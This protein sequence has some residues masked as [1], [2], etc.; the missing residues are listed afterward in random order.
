MQ[1]FYEF[2]LNLINSR[3]NLLREAFRKYS[4]AKQTP[5][6][7]VRDFATYLAQWEA[8]AAQLPEPYTDLRHCCAE[9]GLRVAKPKSAISI[10][11]CHDKGLV[12]AWT[13]D[14]RVE[15]NFAA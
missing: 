8:Q 3:V 1:E 6:Q 13:L 5:E 2:L 14:S 9:S 15:A 10:C 4:D 7:T 12:E 11:R